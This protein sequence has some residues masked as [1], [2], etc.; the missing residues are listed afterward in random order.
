VERARDQVE[1]EQERGDL[2]RLQEQAAVAAEEVSR[3][4][5][6]NAEE[7]REQYEG[8]LEFTQEFDTIMAG[9]NAPTSGPGAAGGRPASPLLPK[10]LEQ[11][12]IRRE[13][14]MLDL[15]NMAERRR[16]PRQPLPRN[17]W[18]RRLRSASPRR[19]WRW[20][21]LPSSMLKRT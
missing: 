12:R 17:A 11:A 13:R 3:V 2:T 20:R 6:G 10:F 14:E 18:S 21:K 5:R 8:N 4:V 16:R 9:L 1:L 15:E 7:A 19:W